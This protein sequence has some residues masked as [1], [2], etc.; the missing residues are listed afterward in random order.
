MTATIPSRETRLL[1]DL[2]ERIAIVLLF[3]WLC[4]RFYASLD[5]T[6]FNLFFLV[7]EGIVALFVLFRR[8]TENISIKPF[9]WAVGVIGTMLPMLISPSGNGWPIGVVFLIAGL[10]ISLGAKIS[11][12]RSFGVVAAN[13]GVKCDGLYGAVR[14]PMYL[15]Y[16][17]TY[18]G[19][20]MLNPSVFNAALL[21]LW[22]ACQIARI[23]AEERVLLQ[24]ATYQAHAR[25][26]RFRLI[27]YV[28]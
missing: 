6:P 14:H 12:R 2:S 24:D 20:L 26:V 8:A 9:D 4:S 11:L 5:E 7:S 18:A 3:V 27:P 1:L 21:T 15:G 17:L 19:V 25:K 10:G 22:A 23:I 28:Y 13:R 16:F